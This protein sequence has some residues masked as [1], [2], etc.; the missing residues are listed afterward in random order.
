MIDELMKDSSTRD[1]DACDAV[2]AACL[3]SEDFI[4]GRRAFAEKRKPVFRGR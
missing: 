2:L 1:N 3:T 4:E